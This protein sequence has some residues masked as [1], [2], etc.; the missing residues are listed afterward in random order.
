MRNVIFLFIVI[1]VALASACKTKPAAVVLPP[2]STVDQKEMERKWKTIDSLEQKGLI[3]S[4]L[5]EVRK[6]KEAARAGNDSGHLVKAI[7]HENKYLLQLEE[8]SS[9]KALERLEQEINTY[10]EPAKSVMHSL[11]GQWYGQYLQTHLWELRNRTEF[12]GTPGPDI[13]TW[14]MRHHIDKIHHHYEQSLMWQGLKTAPVENYAL[15]LTEKQNTDDLRPTL[16]DILMHRALDFF[17]GTESY[18]TKPAYDYVLTDPAAFGPAESFVNRSFPTL[19]SLSNTWK[20]LQWYQELLKFRLSDD[21]HEAAL[22]DA[23]LKRLRFV[24]D[25]IVVEA[26]DSL[27]K[28]SLED[29]SKK[30]AG[31]PESTLVDYHT[32]QLL[33]Q[34]AALWS[35]NNDSPY[36]YAYKEALEICKEAIKK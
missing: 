6:I 11:A 35:G 31:N 8:D 1:I 34:Q 25:H 7:T 17:S 5:D 32:A 26:K 24:Y 15:L 21:R 29:L 22:V 19:D 23:D 33:M 2:Q 18:L 20:A 14:G 30:H 3:A 9:V 36:R 13:R 4:A 27:Y 12:G 28:N 10:P 16:Y